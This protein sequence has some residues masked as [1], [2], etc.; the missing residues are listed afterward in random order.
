[1]FEEFPF[2]RARDEEAITYE[3]KEKNLP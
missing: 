3:C 2:E 1:M